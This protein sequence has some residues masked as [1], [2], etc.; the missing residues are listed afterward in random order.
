MLTLESRWRAK[1]EIPSLAAQW[2]HLGTFNKLLMPES[3]FKWP[4]VGP[5]CGDF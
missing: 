3:R 1:P 2:N 4:V 5:G